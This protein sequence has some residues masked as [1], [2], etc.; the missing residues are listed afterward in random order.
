MQALESFVFLCG[1]FL[2][3]QADVCTNS[4]AEV[5]CVDIVVHAFTRKHEVVETE[6]EAKV[7]RSKAAAKRVTDKA[8]ERHAEVRVGFVE[9]R[10]FEELQAE[11]GLHAG[12]ELG[13]DLETNAQRCEELG[14]HRIREAEVREDTGIQTEGAGAQKHRETR[15]ELE[16][17]GGRHV[18]REACTDLEGPVL[19]L[20]GGPER[21]VAEVAWFQVDGQPNTHLEVVHHPKGHAKR[22]G[23]VEVADVAIADP[24]KV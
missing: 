10:V 20:V 5:P 18:E 12:V 4:E 24:V 3:L 6:A 21:Q 15:L 11:F 19:K 9:E 1:Q 7:D 13:R 14:L 8:V 16:V 2:E 23:D 17:R 22:H